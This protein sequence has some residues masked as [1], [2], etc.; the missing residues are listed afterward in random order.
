MYSCDFDK[1]AN[2]LDISVHDLFDDDKALANKPLSDDGLELRLQ[3][4]EKRIEEIEAKFKM[5]SC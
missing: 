3:T 2:A 4:L 5:L 1:I